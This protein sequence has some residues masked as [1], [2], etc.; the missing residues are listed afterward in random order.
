MPID[1]LRGLSVQAIGKF[2]DGSE[3]PLLCQRGQLIRNPAKPKWIAPER[4]PKGVVE[5]LFPVHTPDRPSHGA[6]RSSYR[7]LYQP[8]HSPKLL[9]ELHGWGDADDSAELIYLPG[10]TD[11]KARLFPGQATQRTRAFPPLKTDINP[12]RR[13]RR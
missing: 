9:P 4:N 3:I 1:N 11:K 7:H 8:D 5:R 2:S 6:L 13:T 12:Y 10:A